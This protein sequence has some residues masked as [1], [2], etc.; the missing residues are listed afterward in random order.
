MKL[1]QFSNLLSMAE[2]YFNQSFDGYEISSYGLD[3]DGENIDALLV[4]P[5]RQQL[6]FTHFPKRA[7]R[8]IGGIDPIDDDYG[9]TWL[10][11]SIGDLKNYLSA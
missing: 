7:A 6:V 9:V 5:T 1:Y 3:G 11:V 8:K 2:N 4:L 10:F